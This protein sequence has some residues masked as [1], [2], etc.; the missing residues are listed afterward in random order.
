M[1]YVGLIQY[2]QASEKEKILMISKIYEK[3][4]M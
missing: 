3:F 1:T 4:L 2:E